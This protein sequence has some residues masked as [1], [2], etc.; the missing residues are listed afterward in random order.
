MSRGR[1]L[2]SEQYIKHTQKNIL[3]VSANNLYVYTADQ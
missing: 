1:K 3:D 2:Q